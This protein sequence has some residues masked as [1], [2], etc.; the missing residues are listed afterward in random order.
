MVEN[1][2]SSIWVHVLGWCRLPCRRVV[3][4]LDPIKGTCSSTSH[5][6][7]SHVISAIHLGMSTYTFASYRIVGSNSGSSSWGAGRT[8]RGAR[9]GGARSRR[10]GR[11]GSSK[12]PRPPSELFRKRQAPEHFLSRFANILLMFYFNWCITFSSCLQPLLH[13]TLF[14][15]ALPYPC[16]LGIRSLEML[17]L[18]RPVEVEWFP[19]TCEL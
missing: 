16:Y 6:S 18:L 10:G 1:V 8:A 15:L 14:T 19:V 11:W 7:S 17:S 9:A 2:Y 3:F 13:Y 12:V 5:S 4:P